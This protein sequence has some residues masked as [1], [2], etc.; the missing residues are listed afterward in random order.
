M[1]FNS[2]YYSTAYGPWFPWL[3]EST[4]VEELDMEE[5]DCKLY[6]N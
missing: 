6:T 5:A 1:F 3:V 4:G 2:K